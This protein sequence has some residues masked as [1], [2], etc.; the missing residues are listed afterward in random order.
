MKIPLFFYYVKKYCNEKSYALSNLFIDTTKY[1][2]DD[3]NEDTYKR[4]AVLG[5]LIFFISALTPN[6]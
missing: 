2:L 1:Y 4:F 3:W 5:P 6:H